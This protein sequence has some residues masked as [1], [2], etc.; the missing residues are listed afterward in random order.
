MTGREPKSRM[1]GVVGVLA[2]QGDSA[3]KRGALKGWG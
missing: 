3:G 2:L 1:R